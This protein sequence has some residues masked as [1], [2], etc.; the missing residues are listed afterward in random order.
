MGDSMN[1]N[2]KLAFVLAVLV[3][4]GCSSAPM[5]K[6]SAQ[7]ITPAGPNEVKIVFMR[8]SFVAGAIGADLF[9][10]V[11]G[12]L[13]YIGSLGMGQKIVY[14]TTPGKKVFMAYGTAA[15]FM[16]GNIEGGKIYYSIVRPNWGSGGMIPTPIRNDGT[17][18][19]NTSIKE[20]PEW[21]SG[22][23]LVGPKPD[24][25][26]WFESK[27]ADFTKTYKTYWDKFQTKTDA[28]KAERTLLSKDGV[29]SAF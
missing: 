29:K 13:K 10:V 23:N 26:A 20:F 16:L 8:T 5:M 11:N 19:Y 14:T 6:L 25:A 2:I 21:V 22:T 28:Q 9:E 4:S 27:K 18:D 12:D 3:L 1:T 7:K 17:T 15:D 24:A